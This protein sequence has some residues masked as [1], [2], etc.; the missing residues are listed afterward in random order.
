MA[1]VCSDAVM[2]FI[3]H[4]APM[5][6]GPAKA[7]AGTAILILRSGSLKVELRTADFQ[8]FRRSGF[9]L[10]STLSDLIMRIA[11]AGT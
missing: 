10:S 5:R 8:A 6:P 2:R 11:A 9:S 7:A 3:C 4:Q 1:A